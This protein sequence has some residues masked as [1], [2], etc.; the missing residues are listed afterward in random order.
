MYRIFDVELLIAPSSLL[1]LS[2]FAIIVMNISSQQKIVDAKTENSSSS[3]FDS[4]LI[5]FVSELNNQFSIA[6]GKIVTFFSIASTLIAIS[7]HIV[8]IRSQLF[9]L[10][11]FIV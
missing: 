7:P 5:D 3:N 11:I 8:V 10:N 1:S 4:Q 2:Y 9:T 6:K